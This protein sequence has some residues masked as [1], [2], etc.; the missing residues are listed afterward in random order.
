MAVQ[1]RQLKQRHSRKALI[2]TLILLVLIHIKK[3]TKKKLTAGA[4]NC[5]N[6]ILRGKLNC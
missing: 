5:L 3:K 1:S 2:K 6:V 4:Y